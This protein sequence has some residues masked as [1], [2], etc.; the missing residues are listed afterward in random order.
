MKQVL[1]NM[2]LAVLVVA[3]VGAIWLGWRGDIV[4]GEVPMT[5]APTA[6]LER[7]FLPEITIPPQQLPPVEKTPATSASTLATPPIESVAPESD[8][9][10][11]VAMED[12]DSIPVHIEIRHGSSK[13]VRAD[14]VPIQRNEE[15]EINPPSGKAGWYGPP[16]WKTIPGNLSD[17]PGV[18]AAHVTYNSKPDVFYHLAEARQGD[19]AILTYASGE[20]AEFIVDSDPVSVGKDDVVVENGDYDW[21]WQLDQPGRVISIITC[22]PSLGR[23]LSGH[24][25]NNWVVQATRVN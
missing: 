7:E 19:T 3:S 11:E 16:E 21:V 23:D 8:S 1:K 12:I 4:V 15:G 10:P 9:E 25:H 14:I 5:P 18:L 20:T 6:S 24:S 2:A 17:H 13:L 22:D